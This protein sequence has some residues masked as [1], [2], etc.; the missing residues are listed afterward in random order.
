[1]HRKFDKSEDTE[2]QPKCAEKRRIRITCGLIKRS[3][4]K[5]EA[6]RNSQ[7]ALGYRNREAN[8]VEVENTK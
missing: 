4:H 7:A 3:L 2:E 1:M 6:I 5:W 8:P